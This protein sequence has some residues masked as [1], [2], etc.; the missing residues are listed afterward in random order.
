MKKY[1][2]SILLTLVMLPANA[3]LKEKNLENTLSILRTELTNYRSELERQSGYIKEQ[4]QMV[5]PT[6]RGVMSQSN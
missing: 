6:S 5:F 2:L 1:I 3:V 4:Q